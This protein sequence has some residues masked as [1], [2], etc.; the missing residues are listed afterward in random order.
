MNL[1]N[2]LEEQFSPEDIAS[3]RAGVAEIGQGYVRAEHPWHLQERLRS[4]WDPGRPCAIS[5][6]ADE[7]IESPTP[8]L[9]DD[10]PEIEY[11][12]R[13]SMSY[14]SRIAEPR[15]PAWFVGFTNEF[16]KDIEKADRKLQG[17]ILQAISRISSQPTTMQGDTIKP[18]SSE[19]KGLWRYR[20]GDFRL[21]YSPDVDTRQVVLVAFASRGGVYE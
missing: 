7:P 19:M 12:E 16:V 10:V 14:S 9:R 5:Y 1:T 20:V 21:V 4:I 2:D 3:I 11:H 8:E 13:S 15:S 17:R 6:E 18:L